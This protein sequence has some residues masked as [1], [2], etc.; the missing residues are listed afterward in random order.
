MVNHENCD[1]LP[2]KVRRKFAKMSVLRVIMVADG[3]VVRFGMVDGW[4]ADQIL[5]VNDVNVHAMTSTSI[6]QHKCD[7]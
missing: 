2:L 6:I 4:Y 1:T 7:A 5:M 3:R